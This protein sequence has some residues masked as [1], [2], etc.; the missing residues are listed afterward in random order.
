M[1]DG[2][3]TVVVMNADASARVDIGADAGA[4]VPDLTGF[5][6]GLLVGGGVLLVGGVLLIVIPIVRASRR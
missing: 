2:D 1:R 5:A 3:W 6:A 4:T